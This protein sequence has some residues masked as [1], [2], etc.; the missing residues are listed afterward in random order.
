MGFDW[1]RIPVLANALGELASGVRL[2]GFDG[3]P[4]H[5]PVLWIDGRGEREVLLSSVDLDLGFD[6]HLG[7]RERIERAAGA[8]VS[9]S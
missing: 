8:V 2:S 1:R 6:P 3:K 7:W 9:A 4:E 5:L